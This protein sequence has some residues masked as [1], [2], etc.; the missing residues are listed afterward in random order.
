MNY[1][2]L[3]I[4]GGVVAITGSVFLLLGS[5]GILRMPDSYNRI[6]A[7]TKATTLGTVLSV[8]GLIFLFPGWAG[9]LI[10]LLLFVLITNP[11][12]SH[13]LGRAAYHIKIP[14][15]KRT[16]VDQLREKSEKSEA[17]ESETVNKEEGA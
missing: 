12:S 16:T 5:L 3:E 8:S 11:V 15:S 1:E 6:Q 7:G 9:K 4:V 13:V 17:T 14:L 2:I 10:I